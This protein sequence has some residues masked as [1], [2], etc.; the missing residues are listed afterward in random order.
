MPKIWRGMKIDGIHPLVAP[1][2]ACGLGIRP[3]DGTNDDIPVDQQGVVYPKTGGMSVSPSLEL[4]PPHRLPR[5]L[6][7]KYPDRF[8]RATAS[9]SYYCW[10]MGEGGFGAEPIAAGL[11]FRPDPDMPDRHGFIEPDRAMPLP[12]YVRALEATRDLWQRW[13]E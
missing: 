6:R 4:I 5:R 11:A 7:D 13:E 9:N 10:W 2:S 12:E 1:D 8:A 3:G